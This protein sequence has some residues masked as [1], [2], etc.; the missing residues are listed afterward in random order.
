M[1]R[2]QKPSEY[3]D[4]EAV[5]LALKRLGEID[6]S[7]ER[8]NGNMTLQINEIKSK[9]T[10]T[11][12]PL[13]AERK[14]IEK[15]IAA[16]AKEHKDAFAKTRSRELTFGTIAFRVV[17][18][19]VI[20]SKKAVLAAMKALNLNAYIRVKEEP[21]KEAMMGLDDATLAR[22]GVTRKIEDKLRIEPNLEKV[23]EIIDG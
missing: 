10:D 19:L 5:D 3:Q 9:A 1:A 14:A 12:A 21:D 13:I 2:R 17:K 7:L 11:A 18:R 15:E 23:K 16:F 6:I 22:I 8:I 4:W 20:P